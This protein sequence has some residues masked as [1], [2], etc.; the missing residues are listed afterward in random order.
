MKYV[1]LLSILVLVSPVFADEDENSTAAENSM[2]QWQLF[3]TNLGFFNINLNTIF[4]RNRNTIPIV[5]DNAGEKNTQTRDKI[6]WLGFFTV[7]TGYGI[8]WGDHYSNPDVHKYLD[9]EWNKKM[10]ADALYQR[11]IR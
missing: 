11:I 1:V 7:M 5:F 10:E 2:F 3:N 4:F 9:D 8:L 6:N